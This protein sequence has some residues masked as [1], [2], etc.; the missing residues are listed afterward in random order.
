MDNDK[1]EAEKKDI[2]STIE[3]INSKYIDKKFPDTDIN[4]IL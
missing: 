4:T 3:N 1:L 2:L